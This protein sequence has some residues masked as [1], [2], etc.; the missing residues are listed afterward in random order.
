MSEPGTH[1]TTALAGMGIAY[2]SLVQETFTWYPDASSTRLDTALETASGEYLG[3]FLVTG[4]MVTF[5]STD[6]NRIKLVRGRDSTF[7]P[8]QAAVSFTLASTSYLDTSG[9]P[10]TYTLTTRDLSRDFAIP[11][12]REWVAYGGNNGEPDSAFTPTQWTLSASVVSP[13]TIDSVT[14]SFIRL[15]D[16]SSFLQAGTI[17]FPIPVFGFNYSYLNVTT[18]ENPSFDEFQIGGDPEWWSTTE[19]VKGS[20]FSQPDASDRLV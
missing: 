13:P 5:N 3:G 12:S 7:G 17:T 14:M 15:P 20:E 8:P 11:I 6:P 4:L 19:L 1:F 18:V 9:D 16:P 10:D 2:G